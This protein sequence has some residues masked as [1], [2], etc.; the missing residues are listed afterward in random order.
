MKQTKKRSYLTELRVRAR[1]Y[2]HYNINA[3]Q[4]SWLIRFQ[5]EILLYVVSFILVFLL[6][7]G[8][9]TDFISFLSTV[10][11]ILIGLFLTSLVF[12]LD[13]FYKPIEGKIE[14]YGIT[15]SKNGNC[16]DYKLSLKNLVDVTSRQKLWNNQ[17]YN[18]VKKFTF[19][20]GH[21]IVL[22][23][24][25]LL[26]LSLS[27][28]FPTFMGE[29]ITDYSVCFNSIGWT[30]ITDFCYILLLVFQRFLIIYWTLRVFRN[31]LFVI[32]SMVNFMTAQ[33][34]R[35]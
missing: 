21:N 26:L 15:L 23:I 25:T 31:T 27:S 19:L 35:T 20:T 32:S 5:K 1:E 2:E 7:S 34:D 16:H 10:L 33:L 18:Y 4:D 24:Y 12:A 13:K 29:D 8:F 28:L 9:N 17:A 11:S 3:V 30:E 6:K 14:D 22:S